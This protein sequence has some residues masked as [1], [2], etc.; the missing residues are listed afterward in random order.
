MRAANVM[1]LN[2]Q[3]VIFKMCSV[4]ENS[5]FYYPTIIIRAGVILGSGI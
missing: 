1:I 3:V 2:S 4:P 5:L